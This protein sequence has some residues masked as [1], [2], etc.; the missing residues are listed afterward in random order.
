[1]GSIIMLVIKLKS[2]IKYTKDIFS[3]LLKIGWSLWEASSFLDKLPDVVEFRENTHA[4]WKHGTEITSFKHTNIPVVECS[5][6]GFYFC[7]IINNHN[8]MYKFCPFCG[9]TMDGDKNDE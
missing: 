1:M 6:C 2:R 3:E 9:A 7:D 8:F 4:H 5:E